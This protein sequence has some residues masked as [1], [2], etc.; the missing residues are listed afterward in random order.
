MIEKANKL[1]SNKNFI[2]ANAEDYIPEENFDYTTCFFAFH[3]MPQK[4]RKKIIEN[5]KKYT[6]EKIIIV[7]ISPFKIPSKFM[8]SVNLIC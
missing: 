6:N 7:D 2:L 5:A 4:A 3:E 8:L 1:F